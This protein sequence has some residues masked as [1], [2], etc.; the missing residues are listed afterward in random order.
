[1][2]IDNETYFNLLASI[3]ILIKIEHKPSFRANLTGIYLYLTRF[4]L[5]NLKR[6]QTLYLHLSRTFVVLS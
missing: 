3:I 2:L 1:M 5:K 6:S 4:G